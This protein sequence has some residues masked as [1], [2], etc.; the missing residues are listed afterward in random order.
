[1]ETMSKAEAA[2][3][4]GCSVRTLERT[5]PPGTPGR[6][7]VGGRLRPAEIRYDRAVI[8]SMVPAPGGDHV[9]DSACDGGDLYCPDKV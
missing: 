6:V 4:L 2:A 8:T 9:H 5:F 1:M 7:E 3:A